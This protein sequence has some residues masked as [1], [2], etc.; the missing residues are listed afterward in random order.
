MYPVQESGVIVIGKVGSVCVQRLAQED[1]TE[2]NILIFKEALR[3][4]GEKYFTVLLYLLLYIIYCCHSY[5]CLSI[6]VTFLD[7][8]NGH[9]VKSACNAIGDIA[10]TGPLPF[11]AESSDKSLSKLS[12]FEKLE[13]LMVYTDKVVVSTILQLARVVFFSG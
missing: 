12:L 9:I 5:H 6:L 13:E 7:C 10:R 8:T 2:D 11:P 3:R 4:L 1:N